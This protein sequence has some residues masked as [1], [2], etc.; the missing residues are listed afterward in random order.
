MTVGVR[1][2]GLGISGYAI[3]MADYQAALKAQGLADASQRDVVLFR[4][5]WNSLWKDYNK[6]PEQREKDNA[7][8]TSGEPGVSPEVCEHLTTRKIA[9]IG[10]DTWGL[11]HTILPKAPQNRLPIVI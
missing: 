2:S 9:M 11:G 7:E 10:S 4:T 1:E 8:F 3:T 5:G 6:P